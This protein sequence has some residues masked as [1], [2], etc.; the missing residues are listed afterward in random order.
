MSGFRRVLF[1]MT[2]VIL[3]VLLFTLACKGPTGPAGPAGPSG[4]AGQPG[5]PG[6]AGPRGPAGETTGTISGTVASS[7]GNI[8]VAG[9]TIATEPAIKDL[10][11]Q[12]DN[13]GKYSAAV[14]VGAYILSFKKDNYTAV[15]QTVAVA[16]G[17]TT[18]KD[19]VLKATKPVVV[20][21]GKALVA[22]PG[23]TVNLSAK[24]DVL[25]GSQITG[26]K[27]EQTAG[28]SAAIADGGSANTAVTLADS[29][30][31]KAKLVASLE[32]QD[33]F[34]VQPINPHSLTE[35]EISTFKVTVNT[36]S[37][38]YSGT[39]SVDADL[40]YVINPGLANVPINVAVLLH[41][42]KQNS[43]SWS[44]AAPS[45]SAA[46]LDS[47]S[48]QNPFFVPDVAG[49]YTVTEQNGKAAF[50]VFAGTW[51]GAI[52][53]QDGK[54]RPLAAGCTACHDGKIAPDKFT[55]WR[56]SGHAEIFTQ[57]IEDPNG[58]WAINC[59]QC[60]T[61]GY[62]PKAK[63]N[64]F[65][66]AVTAEGWKVPPGG[67]RGQWAT[68]LE[69]FPKTAKL[70]NIQ[71]E[72]C[73]G[74][75]NSP[76]HMN[77]KIDA[78]RVN[79]SADSCGACH[80]EPLRHGRFQQWEESG[81]ANFELALAQAT[82][83]GRGAT[84]AHC[85]R[86]H[87]AQGFL[88]WIK[89]GDLTKQIQGAKGNATV[90]ELTAMG[91]TKDKVQPQTCAM[92]HNP[93]AE[94]STTGEPN[95]ASVRIMEDTALLPSGFQA[96]SLGRGALCVTCHNTR[97]ALHNNDFLPNSYSAPHTA[98]QGDVLMGE[99]AYLVPVG[100]RSPHSLI[101]DS[102]AK[103]HMESTPPPAEFSFQGGGTNHSFKASIKICGDCHSKDLDG[104]ALQVGVEAEEHELAKKMA[105]YLMN[106]M[107]AQVHIKDYTPHTFQGK[108]Y[109][110][111]SNDLT[112]DKTN[113]ASIEATEP[114]GQQG[115]TIHFKNPVDVTYAPPNEAPHTVSVKE[116]EVQLGDFTTDGKVALI[117]VTDPLVKAGW[118]FFLIEGDGS[119]GVHNPSFVMT[120]LTESIEALK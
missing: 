75:N 23:A 99:N 53:G 84:A 78:E 6:A 79:L 18:T 51:E 44:L 72:N 97:N 98:A 12:T 103:C 3:L 11:V 114:H 105:D 106:K 82:V 65:A 69:K 4:T 9:V 87:S 68:I 71:C 95:T 41:G 120:V 102:C 22:N 30:A 83:E 14:P 70:A 7:F 36:T 59:A 96:K 49:K 110:I 61:V 86:C 46:S 24:A 93:H 52:T 73:H 100:F 80:G 66:E 10:K 113:I 47:A 28:P 48:D 115:F 19:V 45:G 58:H 16:A 29:A 32:M 94:G 77:G 20:D 26:Y 21:A 57:N 76:L 43:Y 60:H 92:C 33:R 38:S 90:A 104:R 74:P 64:N 27:W 91:L 50:D 40:P 81:H 2:T 119:R 109:D 34:T 85:G 35:A 39:V 55:E 101:K 8:P 37:G 17:Q 63:N 13:S 89:Q 42:K 112:I 116:V 56:Q 67:A 117:A 5:A 25:D 88:N 108:S 111:K 54:G 62:N 118:N 15:S 1:L 107:P 31:H